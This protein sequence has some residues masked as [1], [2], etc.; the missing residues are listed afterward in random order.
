M[1]LLS[2]RIPC[3]CLVT[4]LFNSYIIIKRHEAERTGRGSGGPSHGNRF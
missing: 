4:D 3:L 1:L 2:F